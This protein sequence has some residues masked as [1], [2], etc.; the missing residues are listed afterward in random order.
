MDK[1]LALIYTRRFDA[2]SYG[3][4][5]PM[6]V[7]RYRLTYD[8]M[9]A[10]GLIQHIKA[11]EVEAVPAT[12]EELLK[13]HRC[14]YLDI[15]EQYSRDNNSCANFKY[16][17]GDMENPVFEG[18]YEWISLMCGGTITAVR[19]VMQYGRRA[20]FSMAGGWHHGFPARASGFCYLNDVVVALKP[21]LEEGK[22]IVYVDLDAHH[23]DG[24]Q[25]AFYTTDQVLTISIHEC[26]K[27]FY[28]YSG[29]VRESGEGQGYGYSVNVPL[30]SHS[31]DLILEQ[32]LQRIVLPLIKA[33]KPDL[34]ITQMGADFMRTD[35]LT[36][37]EGT[38]AF[39]EYAARCFMATGLPWVAV[40]GGGYDSINVARA[41]TM[42]WAAMLDVEVPYVLPPDFQTIIRGAGIDQTL[43]RDPPHL[44]NPDD[45]ARAQK[46]LDENVAFLERRIFP[47][48]HIRPGGIA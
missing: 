34:L 10:C 12:R 41:W 4:L 39:M 46:A 42:L 18:L 13:F 45:F 26:G 3:T 14:D 25:Q 11:E 27:D 1:D 32:A 35:P 23:G 9:Q 38:T 47:L 33:Y 21:L 31:D 48:Y 24:V 44:A 7:E 37:L 16:G 6:K 5:H 22:R 15:L 36:R 30:V 2:Y 40:G 43:L 20:A 19:E 8:L 28:P 29:F 17:L